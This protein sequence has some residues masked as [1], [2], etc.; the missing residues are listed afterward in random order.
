[1]RFDQLKKR[2]L[3][4]I[5]VAMVFGGL[6]IATAVKGMAQATGKIAFIVNVPGTAELYSIDPDGTNFTRVSFNNIQ[7]LPF[8][9]ISR[10]GSRVVFQ[11]LGSNNVFIMN[12]DGSNVRQLTFS[13]DTSAVQPFRLTALRSRIAPHA[14]I[15]AT[16]T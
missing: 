16:F 1:M 3:K 8:I 4:M 14:T 11:R 5:L 6:V 2:Q 10:D 15:T 7:E 9:D 13:N 12:S